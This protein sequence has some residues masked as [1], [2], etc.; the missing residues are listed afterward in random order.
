MHHDI[1]FH[2]IHIHPQSG[3]GA[4]AMIDHRNLMPAV[5]TQLRGR[6]QLDRISR[7][8]LGHPDLHRTGGIDPDFESIPVRHR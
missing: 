4:G 6:F 1:T 8:L 5:R 2:P 7:P 3:R